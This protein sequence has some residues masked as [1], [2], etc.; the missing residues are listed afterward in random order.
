MGLD[1]RHFVSPVSASTA[2]WVVRHTAGSLIP[3]CLL[4]G[5]LAAL[6]AGHFLAVQGRIANQAMVFGLLGAIVAWKTTYGHWIAAVCAG[7]LGWVCKPHFALLPAVALSVPVAIPPTMLPQPVSFL[8]GICLAVVLATYILP[9]SEPPKSRSKGFYNPKN[10]QDYI[11]SSIHDPAEVFLSVIIPAYNEELRLP[12]M[13]RES[14][15][16]LTKRRDAHS[17]F[18]FELIV[19]DD[20]SRDKTFDETALFVKQYGAESVRLLQLERNCGKGAAVREGMLRARGQVCLFADADGAA[21]VS[22]WTTLYE[23]IKDVGSDDMALAIG[24]REKQQRGGFRLLLSWGWHFLVVALCS[25][26]I[27]DTQCGYKLFTRQAARRI[28]PCQR[29]DRWSFDVEILHLAGLLHAPVHPVSVLVWCLSVTVL[30]V[31]PRPSPVCVLVCCLSVWLHCACSTPQFTRS[32]SQ[33]VVCLCVALCVGSTP[34]VHPVVCCR[35]V[36]VGV[37]MDAARCAM[38]VSVVS[39]S[40]SVLCVCLCVVLCVCVV[41]LSRAEPE[42][43]R[44]RDRQCQLGVVVTL[45]NRF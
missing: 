37:S 22:E 19:V 32:V 25:V 41:C 38:S 18:T 1:S 14:L 43:E 5:A 42:S 29:L 31:P 23:Q 34:P 28:F 7:L 13:L 26:G 12:P 2:F 45:P 21:P 40:V 11:L 10:P 30:C 8:L 3:R 6:T 9:R 16:Y 35:V 17:A 44:N 36:R 39:V 27:R 20:G 33:C 4:V 24:V 15:N